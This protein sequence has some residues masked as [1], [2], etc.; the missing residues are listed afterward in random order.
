MTREE[1]KNLILRRAYAGAFEDGIKKEF[2]LHTFAAENGID[3]D[4]AWKA[5]EELK[6]A[7]LI[8][9]YAMG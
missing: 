1:N 4:A 8:D 5:F 7:G 6:S 3:N 9:F 2:N